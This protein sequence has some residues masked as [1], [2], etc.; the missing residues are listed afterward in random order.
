M[1]FI[2]G[3]DDVYESH[4]ALS[5]L[6]VGGKKPSCPLCQSWR[7]L[8]HEEKRRDRDRLEGGWLDQAG[9]VGTRIPVLLQHHRE[10]GRHTARALGDP[11]RATKRCLSA[12]SEV[13][14]STPNG[15]GTREPAAR[16]RRGRPRR[17]GRG[18][19]GPGSA[20]RRASTSQG[21]LS[22]FDY[23]TLSPVPV[24]RGEGSQQRAP[25]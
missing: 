9:I 5:S 18:S 7:R 15:A 20:G 12:C 19:R 3:L 6:L 16:G 22:R 13:A 10:W 11:V 2:V 17:S 21:R 25:F 4:L 1:E 14:S 23:N 8:S 24:E